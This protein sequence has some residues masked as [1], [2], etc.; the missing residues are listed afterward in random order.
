MR[1]D[2]QTHTKYRKQSAPIP[3]QAVSALETASITAKT[4]PAGVAAATFRDLVGSSA[5]ANDGQHTSPETLP[6]RPNKLWNS[7]HGKQRSAAPQTT[8]PDHCHLS[9]PSTATP[10]T[11]GGKPSQPTSRRPRSRITFYQLLPETEQS[12]ETYRLPLNNY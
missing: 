9:P 4:L 5:R 2:I 10:D 1:Y 11:H 8:L 6:K 12:S 3:K 7:Q